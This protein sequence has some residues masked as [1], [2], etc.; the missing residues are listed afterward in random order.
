MKVSPR[1][2]LK[3]YAQL[4]DFVNAEEDMRAI[5]P[6]KRPEM[7][8]RAQTRQGVRRQLKDLIQSNNATAQ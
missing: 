8:R 1:D 3:S 4:N 5:V 6:G 2:K 7:H